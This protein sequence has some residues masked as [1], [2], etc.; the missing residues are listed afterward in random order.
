MPRR[1]AWLEAEIP[2]HGQNL[3]RCFGP[4]APARRAREV[5]GAATAAPRTYPLNLTAIGAA[6]GTAGCHG[7]GL[8]VKDIARTNEQLR[9]TL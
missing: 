4:A 7:T 8:V 1:R 3:G 2:V 5:V 9:I 6:C